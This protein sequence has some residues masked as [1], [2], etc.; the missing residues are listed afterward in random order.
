MREQD[1]SHAAPAAEFLRFARMIELLRQ[2]GWSEDS[3]TEFV[4]LKI[5]GDLSQHAERQRQPSLN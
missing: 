3:I 1:R 2:R 4:R 5:Q